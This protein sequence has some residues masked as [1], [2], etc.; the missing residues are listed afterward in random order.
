M[1]LQDGKNWCQLRWDDSFKE[2]SLIVSEP[3][4]SL[5]T[6]PMW[7]VGKMKRNGMAALKAH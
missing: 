6:L 3:I 5:G 7:S 4:G 1:Q 2:N